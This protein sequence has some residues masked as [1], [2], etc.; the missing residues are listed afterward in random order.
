MVEGILLFESDLAASSYQVKLLTK[1]RYAVVTART[2]SDLFSLRNA[3]GISLA[4]LSDHLG[5]VALSVA[6]QSIRKGWPLARILILGKPQIVL[7][8]YLY[9]EA[10]AHSLIESDL[11]RTIERLCQPLANRGKDGG[12]FILRSGSRQM[13][14]DAVHTKDTQ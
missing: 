3:T 11:M 5:S 10:L 14:I 4:I 8:D 6:A 1:L 7:E 13:E 9:D 12:L 2:Q